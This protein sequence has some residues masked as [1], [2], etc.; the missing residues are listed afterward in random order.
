MQQP[1][2]IAYGVE[3]RLAEQLQEWAQTQRCW[4]REVQHLQ[5][6]RNLLRTA[7]PAVLVLRLG[8]DVERELALLAQAH[9]L[10]P[11]TATIV[12]G[13]SDNSALAA[14]AWD[15]GAHY[16]LFPPTPAETLPSILEH[17]LTPAMKE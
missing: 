10:F 17:M 12:L 5:A 15:L 1:Q 9:E 16:V 13:D 8:R 2:I 11:A 4:A 14:L 6:C 7:A 3:G